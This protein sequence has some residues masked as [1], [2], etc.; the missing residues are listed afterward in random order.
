M[1][2][3]SKPLRGPHSDS[4]ERRPMSREQQTAW[5]IVAMG[6]LAFLAWDYMRSHD[7]T[8]PNARCHTVFTTE[9][10]SACEARMAAARL[11]AL[12]GP[13]DP[14]AE[15]AKQHHDEEVEREAEKAGREL[16][17]FAEKLRRE[18]GV[19]NTH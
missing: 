13:V 19:D 14:Q 7:A 16:A 8:D 4:G 12:Y 15:A 5:I 1:D 10:W 3:E 17:D 18:D 6:V 9:G 2:E 11:R